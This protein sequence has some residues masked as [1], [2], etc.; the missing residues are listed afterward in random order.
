[1]PEQRADG[2]RDEVVGEALE[3]EHLHEVAAARADR[4]RDA[5]LAASLGGE[6][7]EDQEDQQDAGRDRERA[8]RREHR[9]ER[10]ALLVGQLERVLLAVVGLE[11]ER[12]ERR[13]RAAR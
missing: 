1:M 2:G 11:P 4:A 9:H 6:H 5:E 10:R 7:H 3:Q 12:C 8:E 13:A